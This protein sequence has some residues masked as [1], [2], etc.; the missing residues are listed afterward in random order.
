[1]PTN[2]RPRWTAG[3]AI[4]LPALLLLAACGQST[5]VNPEGGPAPSSGLRPVYQMRIN[6]VTYSVNRSEQDE[7]LFEVRTIGGA[8]SGFRSTEPP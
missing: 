5:Y 7:S 2:A 8:P 3:L 4:L 6:D 1:M